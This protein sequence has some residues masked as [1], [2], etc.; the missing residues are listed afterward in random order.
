[1]PNGEVFEGGVFHGDSRFK[2]QDSKFEIQNSRFKIQDS[3]FK[4][5][6]FSLFTVHSSLFTLHCSL[7]TVHCSLFT[8]PYLQQFFLVEIGEVKLKV[9]GCEDGVFDGFGNEF[10]CF[11]DEGF[12]EIKVDVVSNDD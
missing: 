5:G 6:N 3:G 4:I 10:L 2:I 12:Q 9:V 8:F 11:G 1:M 7:F